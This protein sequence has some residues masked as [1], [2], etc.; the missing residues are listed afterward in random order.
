MI[1]TV[2][3]V[4]VLVFLL[5]VAVLLF[6]VL[7]GQRAAGD[8]V[9][10]RAELDAAL[11]AQ[12]E[13]ARTRLDAFARGLREEGAGSAARQRTE[14]ATAFKAQNDTIR[15]NLDSVRH[16]VAEEFAR[17]RADNEKKLE[18][19]RRTVDEKLQ[20]TLEKRLGESFSLVSKQLESVSK[21]LGEM[22][23][24]AVGVGDL[25]R[26]LTNVKT[27]GTWGEFQLGN[28]L[29][30]VLTPD[31]YAANVKTNPG[32]NDLV[33]F[34][35]RL[36]GRDA[37]HPVWLPIDSKFPKEDYERLQVAADRADRDAVEAAEKGLERALGAF[38]KDVATKYLAPPATTDFA[39][40]FLPTEGLYA[41]VLRRPG[42]VDALQRDYRV[43]VAGPATL[44]ALLNALRMGFRTLAIEKRSSEV[45]QVLGAVKTEFAKFQETFQKVRDRVAAVGKEL[46]N[47]DVRSRA[48][49]RKL[50]DVEA[51]PPDT[52]GKES[53]S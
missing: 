42:L 38:A 15:A 30:E 36:P 29:A 49:D 53:E 16:T 40:L 9:A 52:A 31:Q 23:G 26:V 21:G 11:R 18:E 4:V 41:E 37:G 25:K 3:L 34:A 8:P 5:V 10:R 19:M 13:V 14:L 33:E 51:L 48:M 46:D 44:T 27:R 12:D 20:T 7:G 1:Q 17:V 28:L 22:Q 35:V 43:N 24:L 45:W 32:S 39:I 6:A 2:L 50:R 47:A